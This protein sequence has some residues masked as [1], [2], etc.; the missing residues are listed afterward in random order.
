MVEHLQQAYRAG[1]KFYQRAGRRALEV[2][3]TKSLGIVE[4]MEKSLVLH[5][6]K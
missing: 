6:S 5:E 3:P 4:G 2:D 1:C